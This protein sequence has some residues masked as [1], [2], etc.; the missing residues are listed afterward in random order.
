[1]VGLHR[2]VQQRNVDGEPYIEC[3]RCGQYREPEH[4][5]GPPPLGP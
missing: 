1:M 3:S 5:E 2:W 4:Y